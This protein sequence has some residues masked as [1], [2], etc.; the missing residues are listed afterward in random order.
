VGAPLMRNRLRY[1]AIFTCL[2]KLKTS[3]GRAIFFL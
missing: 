3:V 2:I 1:S